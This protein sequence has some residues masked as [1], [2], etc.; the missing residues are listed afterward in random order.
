MLKQAALV[1]LEAGAVVRWIAL[2]GYVHP[3]TQGTTR[4]MLRGQHERDDVQ[5]CK[6]TRISIRSSCH[7]VIGPDGASMV[8]KN[9]LVATKRPDDVA[10]AAG[11][12]Q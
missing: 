7:G 8:S 2:S 11:G 4:L 9:N 6:S 10:R 12:L 1:Q 3:G 5:D